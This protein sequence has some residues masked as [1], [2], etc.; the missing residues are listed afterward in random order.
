MLMSYL[1]GVWKERQDVAG[2]LPYLGT[3]E[4]RR[5]TTHRT[6]MVPRSHGRSWSFPD[7]YE[8]ISIGCKQIKYSCL[9]NPMDGGAW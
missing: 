1:D 3:F 8:P 5:V 4:I 9:E 2:Y 6:H 7:L